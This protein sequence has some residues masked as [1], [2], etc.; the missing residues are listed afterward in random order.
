MYSS[1]SA[2]AAASNRPQ[3]A[4]MAATSSSVARSAASPA[5]AGSMMRRTSVISRRN[6]S[7]GPASKRQTRTSASS[8]F[9][10]W[11]GRTRVPMRGRDSISPFAAST[12]IASRKTVRLTPNCSPSAASSGNVSPGANSPRMIRRPSWW[13]TSR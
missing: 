10:P 8:R 7:S 5:A 9:H 6:A 4:T 2:T 13:T 3:S 1:P 12:L 11:R